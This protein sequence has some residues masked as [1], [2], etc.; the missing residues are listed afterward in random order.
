MHG[1]PQML[2]WDY[3]LFCNRLDGV[4]ARVSARSVLRVDQSRPNQYSLTVTG[5]RC[6]DKWIQVCDAMCDAIMGDRGRSNDSSKVLKHS[7]SYYFE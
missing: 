7:E 4:K 2:K 3:G 5:N 1:P 6:T